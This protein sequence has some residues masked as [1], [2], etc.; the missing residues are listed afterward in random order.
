MGVFVWANV[1][2]NWKIMDYKKYIMSE[3][4]LFRWEKMLGYWLIF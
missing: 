1:I 4:Y 2:N 3:M